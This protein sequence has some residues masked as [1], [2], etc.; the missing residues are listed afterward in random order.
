[1]SGFFHDEAVRDV[2]CSFVL[3][4]CHSLCRRSTLVSPSCNGRFPT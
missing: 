4:Q 1:M 2:S 3:L